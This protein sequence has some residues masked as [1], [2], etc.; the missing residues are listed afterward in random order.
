MPHAIGQTVLNCKAKVSYDCGLLFRHTPGMAKAASPIDFKRAFIA[1]IKA[2]RKAKGA[3]QAEM[4]DMLGLP[5]QD[6]YKQY[7]GRSLLPH[8]LVVKFC[9][10]CDVDVTY[11]Y[12]GQGRRPVAKV[13]T[14]KV[15]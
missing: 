1:R 11:L 12:T 3:T 13:P 15:A 9:M 6:H 5:G 7:E 8:H 2:A 10:I 4:A 14:R